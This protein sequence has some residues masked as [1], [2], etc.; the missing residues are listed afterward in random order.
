MDQ[1]ASTSDEN[2]G[3]KLLPVASGVETGGLDNPCSVSVDDEHGST[4]TNHIK[5]IPTGSE[6]TPLIR[7][8]RSTDVT[9]DTNSDS[10]LPT[11]RYGSIP[12]RQAPRLEAK[13]GIIARIDK[14]LSQP[15]T[16]VI[17]MLLI[18]VLGIALTFAANLNTDRQAGQIKPHQVL[19]YMMLLISVFVAWM[20]F[21][22]V[23]QTPHYSRRRDGTLIPRHLL[24]GV[25][26]F[27][28]VSATTQILLF[29][30]FIK[31]S[32]HVEGLSYVFAVYPFFKIAFI[33]FQMYFFYKLSRD[34]IHHNSLPGGVFFVMVTLATNLTIW[35]S[36]FFNDATGAA[37]LSNV[38]WLNHYYFGIEKHDLCANENLTSPAS[39]E[40]HNLLS[41]FAPYISTFSMEYAL[42]ASGLLL[43]VWLVIKK[44][45]THV[46]K[47]QK[48]Q[49]TLWR[50]GFILGLLAIPVVFV[51]YMKEQIAI[52]FTAPK[53]I[54]YVLKSLF[55]L[56]M[57]YCCFKCTSLL[58]EKSGFV[59]KDKQ[60]KLEIYLLGV[61]ALLGFPAFDMASTV[62]AIC[63][64]RNFPILYVLWSGIA[65][66]FELFASCVQF[67]FIRK[68]YQYKLPKV[69]D[70]KAN[71]A[72]KFIRQY[73]SFALVMNISY[74]AS[75]TYELRHTSGDTVI[76]EQFFGKY[77]WFGLS[78]F[79]LPLCIFFYFHIATCYA[80]VV[81]IFS[82]FGPLWLKE[83]N[84]DD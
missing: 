28:T 84:R 79:S 5:H 40:L 73:A 43:D 31:C 9:D 12:G 77:T 78:H 11:M 22:V 3:R 80:N 48:Q 51:A 18:V 45:E 75:K 23:P 60:T 50:F 72:S 8:R 76:A 71:K 69:A 24:T 49:W 19:I 57:M 34:S 25:A 4:N 41:N 68:A 64:W 70:T 55:F 27:G 16:S 42:L 38:S 44:P 59:K 30:D 74:W 33:Y 83:D 17:A 58:N 54:L 82:Q 56:A 36:V 10:G 66:M 1:V 2:S 7:P 14:T 52:D 39:R 35:A 62:A 53:V 6:R 26:I 29:V 65:S 63:E 15:T 46:P 81:S 61:S 47:P 67:Y 13:P 37:K 21:A 20:C 32:K